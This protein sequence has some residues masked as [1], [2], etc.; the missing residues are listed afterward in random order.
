[1]CWEA[2]SQTTLGAAY[3][4]DSTEHKTNIKLGFDP[5]QG[6]HEYGVTWTPTAI[7][8]YVDGALVHTDTGTKRTIPFEPLAFGFILRPRS[9]PYDGDAAMSVAWFNWTSA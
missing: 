2:T 9:A 3:W 7:E 1:M 6:F 8:W 4:F 5:S